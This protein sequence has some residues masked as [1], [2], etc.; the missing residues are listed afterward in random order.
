MTVDKNGKR[1]D[2]NERGA[3][4]VSALLILLLLV[5]VLTSTSRL[6]VNRSS[7]LA[8]DSDQIELNILTT[9]GLEIGVYN[10][11]STSEEQAVEGR[12][13]IILNDSEVSIAWRGENA[14]LDINSASQQ[15]IS[16]LIKALGTPSDQPDK[17]AQEIIERR[18]DTG[19]AKEP[20]PSA[21]MPLANQRPFAHPDELLSIN[22]VSLEL[23]HRLSPFITVYSGKKSIDPRI[24]SEM[25][26]SNLPEMTS[27]RLQDLLTLHGRSKKDS[28]AILASLGISRSDVDIQ[29]CQT[30][31][32]TITVR[33]KSGVV[34]SVEIVAA[35]F[36]NDVEPYRILYYYS[37]NLN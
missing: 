27:L 14:R 19:Q 26:L 2:S 35:I 24:A 5:V 9:S 1:I 16:G 21:R 23:F 33:L 10:V 36:P 30:T 18:G 3:V 8:I 11:M 7:A 17:I 20:Q 29:Q 22:G 15:S 28:V 37:S 31:R 6:I 12:T 32:F 25:V 4:L 13:N 34:R